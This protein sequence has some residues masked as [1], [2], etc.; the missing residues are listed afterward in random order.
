MQTLTIANR[1]R[2]VR[3]DLRWLR[4]AGKLA[5]EKCSRESADQRFAL[6]ALDEVEVAIVSDRVIA[7]VHQRFMDIPGATDVI[8]FEHGEI[9]ISAQTAAHYAA[10]YGHFLEEELALYVIHGMLH[11]NG[12]EDGTRAEADRMH[13]LQTEILRECLREIPIPTNPRPP[14]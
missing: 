12:F 9:V 5:L 7:S 1:Q 3:F 13:K 11:L 2:A 6:G 4:R 8:T 10:T 14:R